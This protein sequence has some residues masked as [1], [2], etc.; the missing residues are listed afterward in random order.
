MSIEPGTKLGPYEI[1]KVIGAGGMGEVYR[2]RDTRL[3]RPVAIKVLA[4][5]LAERPEHRQRLEREAKA[6]SSL[7]HPH[8]CPLYDVGHENGVD[9]LVMEFI[10]G[11]T[12]ADRLARGPLPIGEVLDYGVQIADALERAHK[13]GII[14]RDLKPGNI[15]LTSEGTKLLDFGLAR[16]DLGAESEGGLTVSPTVSK[17]LTAV[18][19]VIGTYQYMAP[20]Q[21][22][23]KTADARTDIFALGAVLY[24]MASGRRAFTANTQASLIGAIMHEQPQPVSTIQPM[25]PPAFDRVLQSCMA[26]A[27]DDRWQTAHDVKLQLQ[28]IAEGG[29]VVGLPAPVAARRRSRERLAWIAFAAALL[30]AAFFAAGYVHRAPVPPLQTRFEIAPPPELATVGSPRI[31]PDGRILVFR[32][33]DSDGN[34]QLW[35]RPMDS[36]EARPLAGTEGAKEDARPMWSPDS[37]FVAFFVGDK[38]KKVP[39]AGGPAQTICDADGA[40]GSWSTRGEILY[41]GEATAPLMRVPAAGGLAKPEVSVE[42]LEGVEALGWPEFLPDGKQFIFLADQLEDDSRV[43]IRSLSSDEGRVLMASDS[44]VQYV[45]PG[46]LVYVL[47]GMLV[48]HP[49][50]AGAGELTGDPVPLAESIGVSAVGLADFSASQNGTLA[51]RAGQT[52]ARKLLWRDRSGRELGQVGAPAEFTAMSLSPDQRRL[53]VSV[54]DPE[55]DNVDLW[56]HDLERGVASRFTFDEGTDVVPLWSPD[57][58]RIVFSSSRGEGKDA[59]YWKDASGAGEAELL[60]QVEDDVYP[61]DWSRDGKFIALMRYD[62]ETRWDIWALPMDGSSEP[63]P[64]LQSEFSEVRPG[65]SPDGRWLVYNSTESGDMEVYV[66][67][68]PGPGGKWQVSTNGGTEPQWSADGSEIF[69]LDATQNLVTVPVSTGDTFTA[70]L[71]QTLFEA[72]LFPLVARNRYLA[73]DDGQRF[74]MLGST[75]GEAIRPISVVLNWQAGFEPRPRFRQR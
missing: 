31:S 70:G 51:Y 10:D 60:L 64:V 35:L 67:R 13:Q 8:I 72:R 14:H 44:R 75:G 45:E 7:S 18:G 39:V 29:S 33:V 43:M 68:F 4:P 48:A 20:E 1:E 6:V 22:E 58:S 2:A 56:I 21:L 30:A 40:D 49:F 57:G 15:M 66:T 16:A 62:D 74:L 69:Y 42:D 61:G 23:G 50:D 17:P 27:A 46:Y 32:G 3:E 41:D 55:G 36:V 63:F 59:L 9:F 37:R 5:H 11:E 47:N 28:W 54:N 34:S 73:T 19:T 71:P 53:V 38:L 65:F 12:L 52:G 24:E 26:K 25:T